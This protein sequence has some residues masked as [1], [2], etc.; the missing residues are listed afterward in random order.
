VLDD[1][2]SFDSALRKLAAAPPMEPGPQ[3]VTDMLVA[4]AYRI[5]ERIGSGGMGVVYRAHDERLDREVALKLPSARLGSETY[6]RLLR[7]AKA[8]AR[9]NHPNVITVHDVGEWNDRVFIAMEYLAGGTLQDWLSQTKPALRE[10]V[11]RFVEAGRGLAAAHASGLTHRDFKPANVLIGADGQVRVGDFGLALDNHDGEKSRS[12]SVQDVA[13]WPSGESDQRIT[14]TGTLLGTVGYIAPEVYAGEGADA[15]S[16][17]F[18]FCVSLWEAIVGRRLF[19][20]SEA[21]VRVAVRA[22]VHSDDGPG[23]RLPRWLRSILLR[24]LSVSPAD[25]WPDMDA[26][27][28]ALERG[29]GRRRRFAAWSGAAAVLAGV[30]IG[31][32]PRAAADQVCDGARARVQE[33]WPADRRQRAHDRIAAA[34]VVVAGEA[35]DRFVG[36]MDAFVEIW[37]AEHERACKD[38]RVFGHQSEHLLDLR[39]TCLEGQWA[40]ANALA[41]LVENAEV[42]PAV[43]MESTDL[44]PLPRACADS[45]A[46]VAEVEG[47]T[48]EQLAAHRRITVE[49]EELP[50]YL[51]RARAYED[52]DPW[53]QRLEQLASEAE[54]AGTLCCAARADYYRGLLLNGLGQIDEALAVWRR[55]MRHATAAGTA[56]EFAACAVSIVELFSNNA[57]GR[58]YAEA[59]LALAEGALVR[60]PNKNDRAGQQ[61]ALGWV[62]VELGQIEQGVEHARQAL[63]LLQSDPGTPARHIAR[64]KTNYG[65]ALL[66]ADRPAD[67]RPLL[68]ETLQDTIEAFGEDSL[69]AAQH[70][71]RLAFLELRSG[72]REDALRHALRSRLALERLGHVENDSYVYTL[73]N[74]AAVYERFNRFDEAIEATELAMQ[75]RARIG[76]EALGA[77]S[78]E[79]LGNLS[80][81]LFGKGEIDRALALGRQ[82]RAAFE[83]SL[84]PRAARVVEADTLLGGMARRAG[85]IPLALEALGRAHALCAEILPPGAG[86]CVNA[87]NELA[88]AELEAGAFALAREHA[89]AALVHAEATG[90]PEYACEVE[91]TLAKALLALDEELPRARRLTQSARDRYAS[92]GPQYAHEVEAIDAWSSRALQD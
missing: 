23:P 8:M 54:E 65:V 14:R 69:Q 75:V 15:R 16:D 19:R 39:M 33:L 1:S 30:S 27:V 52:A 76:G 87:T 20:G 91:L 59:T 37:A 25:R 35:A 47:L 17:Q 34:D 5:A 68:L 72:R 86:Q 90:N 77:E 58:E 21:Q 40:R 70:S 56:R 31:T 79:L 10:V 2:P 71:T 12:S 29:L 45:E 28:R 89:E 26:L 74:L 82:S 42:P 22:G 57:V 64:A 46:L 63:E 84:G 18:A 85:Q 61:S 50:L 53:L 13:R 55:C 49:I 9:L 51:L 24:G 41:R 67:A 3:L 48:A 78:G 32:W 92:L 4:G 66:E 44:L 80:I 83:A 62:A 60:I 11:E 43:L 73:M 7:E 38:T 6:V 36:A 88:A 81:M